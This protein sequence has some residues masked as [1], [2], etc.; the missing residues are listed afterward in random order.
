MAEG[1]GEGGGVW[2]W[3]RKKN[4]TS[5]FPFFPHLPAPLFLLFFVLKKDSYI[6]A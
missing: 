1:F 3:K 2:E 4:T 6:L 5:F